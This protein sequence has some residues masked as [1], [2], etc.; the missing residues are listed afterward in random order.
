MPDLD[1]RLA[2]VEQRL[3]EGDAWRVEYGAKIDK[4]IEYQLRQRGFLAGIVFT[5]GALASGV[6][7]LLNGRFFHFGG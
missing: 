2:K 1:C 3:D 7:W 5:V 4:L 6:T